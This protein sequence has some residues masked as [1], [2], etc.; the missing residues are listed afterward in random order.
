MPKQPQSRGTCTYCGETMAKG[1]M[2]KHLSACAKRQEAI[3]TANPKN[4]AAEPLIHLRVQSADAAPMW[5]DLEMRSS[6]TLKKLDDYLRAIWL[7]CCGHLSEFTSGGA[8]SDT[9]VGM[10]RKAGD[11]LRADVAL[12]HVYDFGTSSTTTIKVVGERTGIPTTKNPIALMA[13][14]LIPEEKCIEC[15]K[16]AQWL[17]MECLYEDDVAGFLCDEHAEDHPHDGYGEPVPLVNSPRVGMCG[18]TGPAEPP[19]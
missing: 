9:K 11:V 17:C 10:S 8:W 15:D 16:P 7:E 3:A 13:R 4:G 14:N 1:G 6:A 2:S 18:Y 12:T 19:Y 5:L